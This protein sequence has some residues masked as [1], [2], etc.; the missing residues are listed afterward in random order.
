MRR[1]SL[2]LKTSNFTI[3]AKIYFICETTI[4]HE[5]GSFLPGTIFPCYLT[6]H[7][8]SSIFFFPVKSSGITCTV[9]RIT[10]VG[11]TFG[12]TPVKSREGGKI[13]NISRL[14]GWDL[15]MGKQRYWLFKTVFTENNQF[16]RIIPANRWR[17]GQTFR[18]TLCSTL[19][20]APTLRC[21]DS[22]SFSS[23]AIVSHRA[24]STLLI[25]SQLI[26]IERVRFDT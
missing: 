3:S 11:F 22:L 8:E 15:T 26:G 17:L 5:K 14:A 7:G 9:F 2:R 21:I 10:F 19:L 1:W 13:V 4:N 16:E 20:V 23:S 6:F 12:N 25:I 24:R 18:V